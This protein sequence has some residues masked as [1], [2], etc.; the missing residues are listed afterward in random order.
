MVIG[1][2]ATLNILS[3]SNA[4]FQI[5][6]NSNLKSNPFVTAFLYLDSCLPFYVARASRSQRHTRS[7][8]DTSTQSRVSPNDWLYAYLNLTLLCLFQT[9]QDCLGMSKRRSALGNQ[10]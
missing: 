9:R 10:S 4:G 2:I 7:Y 1:G 8:Y 5:P 6:L 3:L